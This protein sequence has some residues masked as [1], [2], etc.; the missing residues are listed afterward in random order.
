[1]R[2]LNKSWI[3]IQKIPYLMRKNHMVFAFGIIAT[4][5]IIVGAIV[6]FVIYLGS[7]KMSQEADHPT[8]VTPTASPTPTFVRS[9]V[10]FEVINSSGVTGAATKS[11]RR[12]YS[13]WIYSTECW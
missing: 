11:Q 10:T 4:V 8:K 13:D 3:V 2:I 12:P 1:L 7:S 5:A 6:V 9:A